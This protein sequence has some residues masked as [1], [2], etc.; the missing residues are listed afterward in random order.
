MPKRSSNSSA[1]KGVAAILLLTVLGAG[2]L[3]AYVGL[4]PKAAHVVNDSP[5][6]PDISI[7]SRVTAPPKNENAD[8]PTLLV[9]ALLENDVKLDKPAG[10]VPEGVAPEV[11]L[12]NRT[13]ESLN[14][15]GAR[16]LG[17]DTKDRTA[18]ISFNPGI[19]KGYG[20]I[21]EGHLIKALR[22]ALGQFPNIDRFQLLVDGKVVDSLGNIDLT[23][24]VEVLRPGQKET[25]GEGN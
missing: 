18:M 1:G 19:E 13:L 7:K 2:V 8:G 22:M 15:D 9:P 12:I 3:A 25:T 5:G 14:V 4:N 16:A 6:A 17:I 10:Q 20:T 11:H 21:E 23:T 24:P